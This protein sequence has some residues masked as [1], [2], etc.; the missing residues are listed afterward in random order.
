MI[1]HLVPSKFGF[2]KLFNLGLRVAP[3]SVKFLFFAVLSKVLSPEIYG[4][5]TLITT[6]ITISIFVL[7]LDFYNYSIREI[8]MNGQNTV[9][10]VFSTF[11]LYIVVYIIAMSCVA[12]YY[13]F[14][15]GMGMSLKVTLTILLICITEHFCQEA[16]RLQI[17]FKKV[18]TAN[19][20]FFFR[21]FLWMSYLT[22]EILFFNKNL[23]LET[24]LNYWLIFNLVAV[25]LNVVT[26]VRPAINNKGSLKLSIAFIKRGIV[27]CSLFF[28][29]TLSLKSIEYLNRYIVDLF[30]GKEITGVFSFYSN[31]ALVITVYINAIVISFE[32]P[33]LI[34]KGNTSN[35]SKYFKIFKNS[36][37]KQIVIIIVLLLI[38]IA[39]ILYWQDIP[40]YKDYLYIFFILLISTAIINYSLVYHFYL[41]IKKKD[42]TILWLTIKSGFFNLVTTLILT[43]YF[44]VAGTCVA[45]L[46][47]S[48]CII[49][50]RKSSC[51]KVGYE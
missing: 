9:S 28:L 5:Y 31:L 48:I 45:F 11:L 3:L 18:L 2:Y 38:A 36:F 37:L 33:L 32:L 30:L 27:V 49:Y 16:Y 40:L 4:S 12:V 51:K 1:K 41:Y 14:S 29:G 13:H 34:E 15:D 10:K 7:G 35:F 44:G 43:Y 20:I 24:I 46:L 23:V 39:P 19:L 47:T 8:L 50:L 6:T 17:A 22:I 26:A 21:V 42:R 25:G